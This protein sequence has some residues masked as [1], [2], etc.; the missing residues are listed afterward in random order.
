ME[1]QRPADAEKTRKAA[2]IEEANRRAYQEALTEECEII[3][4]KE[5][6]SALFRRK[7]NASSAAAAVNG[8][9]CLIREVADILGRR[10]VEVLAVLATVLAMPTIQSREK[11]ERQEET[12]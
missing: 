2:S 9:A 1:Q 8:V 4:S 7:I 10:P 5:R 11:E 3:V 12:E 6:G